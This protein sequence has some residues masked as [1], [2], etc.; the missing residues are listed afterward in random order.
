MDQWEDELKIS[1]WKTRWSNCLRMLSISSKIHFSSLSTTMLIWSTNCKLI[2]LIIIKQHV[3]SLIEQKTMQINKFDHF[4]PTE[5]EL[6]FVN[7][8]HRRRFF[9]EEVL[10]RVYAQWFHSK[11]YWHL[12]AEWN[13]IFPISTRVDFF[14]RIKETRSE[15]KLDRDR[16]VNILG[17]KEQ[18]FIVHEC[19]LSL[20][21]S[22]SDSTLN[23][24]WVLF[25]DG[26]IAQVQRHY[27]HCRHHILTDACLCFDCIQRFER[28]FSSSI[29]PSSSSDWE[30]CSGNFS[31]NSSTSSVHHRKE[32]T[33]WNRWKS[34]KEISACVSRMNDLRSSR[35]FCFAL[36]WKMSQIRIIR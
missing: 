17:N 16:N 35:S 27:G 30:Q 22:L 23:I 19:H 5:C 8:W 10:W 21:L 3:E 9:G 31:E 14:F 33:P 6:L 32:K 34:S 36:D 2:L 29:A 7:I 12:F 20:S 25:V 11:H 4:A 1:G 26:W 24:I 15:G 18:P 28:R 13:N